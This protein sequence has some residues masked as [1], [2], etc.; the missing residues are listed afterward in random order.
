MD[1]LASQIYSAA[2]DQDYTTVTKLVR[3]TEVKEI[4]LRQLRY[5]L[6]PLGSSHGKN[7]FNF[8]VSSKNS[9]LLRI[10][11]DEIPEIFLRGDD[12]LEVVSAGVSIKI[13]E[14]L[15]NRRSNAESLI[16]LWSAYSVMEEFLE[17]LLTS[18]ISHPTE[19]DLHFAVCRSISR[20]RMGNLDVLISY[21][22]PSQPHSFMKLTQKDNFTRFKL[23]LNNSEGDHDNKPDLRCLSIAVSNCN[24]SLVE[25]IVNNPEFF[26]GDLKEYVDEALIRAV[27]RYSPKMVVTLLAFDPQSK[28]TALYNAIETFSREMDSISSDKKNDVFEILTLLLQTGTYPHHEIS[29]RFSLMH[30]SVDMDDS[31]RNF[32]E[33]FQGSK[34]KR[35]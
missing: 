19:K 30:P 26:G 11:C 16:I 15:I 4:L 13:P 23:L 12:S 32:I 7:F 9:F 10:L 24:D 18:F 5:H 2:K 1:E 31:I 34:T 14:N 6:N 8:L 3:T 22:V 27:L 33:N 17:I 29:H 25:F 28:T 21:G 35:A 20:E